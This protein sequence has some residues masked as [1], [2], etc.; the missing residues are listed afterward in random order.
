MGVILELRDLQTL[1]NCVTVYFTQ[2]KPMT[3]TTRT[4][5]NFVLKQINLGLDEM[6]GP[7]SSLLAW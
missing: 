2:R 6:Y 4:S 1:V 5:S 3:R 7:P